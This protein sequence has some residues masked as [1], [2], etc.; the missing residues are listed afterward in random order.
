VAMTKTSSITLRIGQELKRALQRL[1][2][3]DRRTM[4]SYIEVILERHVEASGVSNSID[5]PTGPLRKE[6]RKGSK[7]S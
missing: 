3:Q 4:S 6:G 2:D 1:A 5:R 7:G